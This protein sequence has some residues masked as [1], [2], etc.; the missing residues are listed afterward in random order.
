MAADA[1]WLSILHDRA[2]AAA[3]DD[4]ADIR[5]RLPAMSITG[6]AA[7]SLISST[8]SG[9]LAAAPEVLGDDYSDAALA[10]LMRV[11]SSSLLAGRTEIQQRARTLLPPRILSPAPP[12]PPSDAVVS[13]VPAPVVAPV[14]ARNRV[15]AAALTAA[16]HAFSCHRT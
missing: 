16:T 12:A 14:P 11:W 6:P 15:A 5:A 1:A 10:T 9:L 4:D 8:E 2:A 3:A 13:L 7:I